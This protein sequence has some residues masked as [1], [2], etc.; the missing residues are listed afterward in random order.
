ME[1]RRKKR[2]HDIDDIIISSGEENIAKSSVSGHGKK[3]N[4]RKRR[5]KRKHSNN[6]LSKKIG[7]GIMTIQ[8][9]ASVVFM[10]SLFMLGILPT[11]YLGS[12]G[13]VLALLVFIVFGSQ[14]FSKKK[15]ITA[16]V[17]SVL[18]SVVLFICSFYCIKTNTTVEGISGGN[19]KLDRMIAVVPITDRAETIQDAAGYNFGVQY[20]LK[21][22]D[23]AQTV[24]AINSELGTEIMTTECAGIQEQAVML[25]EGQVDAIILNEAYSAMLEDELGDF[26]SNVKII[27]V[28][29][30]TTAI[31]NVAKDVIVEEEAFTV[32]I[33][34]IDV[35]GSISTNSRS[36]V[37]ILAVVNPTTHQILLVTTPRDYYVEFPGV[38]GGQKDKLTH[39]GIYGVDVSMAT[40]GAI[41]D[42]EIDF[43]ARVNFTSVIKMVDALGG[44]DVYSEYAFTASDGTMSAKQGMNHF[45]GEQA[46]RF[47]RERYNVPGGDFQRGKNQ[48][49]VI[50]AMIQ[51]AISPA[52]LTGASE[53][54]STVGENVDTNMSQDQI[55]ELIKSQL[56]NP[57]G[58]KIKSMAAEGTGDSQYCYSMPSTLL[59]VTQPN[60]DSIAAISEAIKAVENG[61]TF[62]DSAVAE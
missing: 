21:G 30:I 18:M 40:L 33:S 48:Q 34:G 14:Y 46:L 55:Q 32:Y 56:A 7:Y 52:I 37:N 59:Y 15:A 45:N 16:K 58:W 35:Y 28:H 10:I 26:S 54:L 42:T 62:E 47:A 41:Y 5:K 1:E 20:A 25:H 24:E 23:V 51:K 43:Y 22:D 44:V 38:T 13:V 29:E 8:A 19:E 9:V 50:V 6:T 27:Y 3:I 11:S 17:L 31:E 4:K 2:K 39:A 49:A 36:D 61:E 12:I 57:Q 53:I 60:Y